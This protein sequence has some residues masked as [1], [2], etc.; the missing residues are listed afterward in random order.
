MELGARK[1]YYGPGQITV[2]GGLRVESTGTGGLRGEAVLV[3][4]RDEWA[5]WWTERRVLSQ[6]D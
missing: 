5:V 4:G 1:C 2:T 6:L 3:D